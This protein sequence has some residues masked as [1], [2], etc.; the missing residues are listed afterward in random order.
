[1]L[2]NQLRGNDAVGR[3]GK[4]SF[5]LLLPSTPQQPATHTIERIRKVLSEPLSIETAREP[6]RLNP[7]A[8]LATHQ[9]NET[10][11]QLAEQAELALRRS[12]EGDHATVCHEQQLE[13]GAQ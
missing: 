9:A 6:L 12:L 2:R 5:A 13:G 11:S 7:G 8:G 3:W 1:L 10:A 4:L